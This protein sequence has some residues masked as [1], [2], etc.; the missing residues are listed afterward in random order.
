[1]GLSYPIFRIPN[2]Q[3]ATGTR[4]AAAVSVGAARLLIGASDM[5]H[6]LPWARGLGGAWHPRPATTGRSP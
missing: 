3:Q 4:P 5:A 1:M 6:R 2:Y